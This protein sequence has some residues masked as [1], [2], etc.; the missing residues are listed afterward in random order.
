[1]AGILVIKLSALGDLVLAFHAFA[2][3]R[4]RHA[5]EAIS[6][7]TTAPFAALMGASPWFDRI[8][9]DSRPAL[10]D[11]VALARLKRQLTGF[12]LVYDLQTSSRSGWYFHLAGRPPW[13]GNVRG[14]VFLHADPKRS[15]QHTLE[16]QRS[17]LAVAGVHDFP[18]PKLGWLKQISSQL[19]P[20]EPFALIVPGAAVHRP[21]K[22]WPVERFAALA[23][24]LLDRGLTPVIVGGASEKVLGAAIRA[25]LAA[26]RDLTGKTD[27]FALAALAAAATV[28]VGNDTGPMHL[29]AILG[30]PSLVLFSEESDPART[31]PRG[32]CGEPVRVLQVANLADLTLEE[33]LAALPL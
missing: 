8:F 13:S 23:A 4:H 20:P 32:P 28:A 12:D 19:K 22:R 17:Q 11:L 29:A 27:L 10:W 26:V 2:A 1:M 6:L 31:A 5:G 9:I 25:Q 16:R 21:A 18:P 14:A 24:E 15:R 7:L 33:V 3:I 30:V